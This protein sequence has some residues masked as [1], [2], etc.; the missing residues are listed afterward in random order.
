MS[1][2]TD[3]WRSNVRKKQL[4]QCISIENFPK[5]G[6]QY[7][8]FLSVGFLKEYVNLEIHPFYQEKHSSTMR[9]RQAGKWEDP[10]SRWQN[11]SS[12]LGIL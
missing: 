4:Q 5:L 6:M 8:L 3:V 11:L 1:I 7:A 12:M 9:A 10:G 2:N